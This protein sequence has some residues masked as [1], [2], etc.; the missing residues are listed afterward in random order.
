MKS[1]EIIS[2]PSAKYDAAGNSGIIN[3]KLKK[4]KQ[5]GTNGNLTLG[6]GM[7]YYLRTNESLSLNHKEGD[8]NFFGSYSHNIYLS[9]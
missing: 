1:I 8:W 7:G 4:N 2:N 5:V 9:I 6:A 3:I